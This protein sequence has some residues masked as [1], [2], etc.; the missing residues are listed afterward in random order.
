MRGVRAVDRTMEGRVVARERA[1]KKGR[2]G[3]W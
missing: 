1:K 3:H 2:G